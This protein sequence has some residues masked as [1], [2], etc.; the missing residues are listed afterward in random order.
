MKNALI[1]I[2]VLGSG[3]VL[4]FAV[5]AAIFVANPTGSTV[6]TIQNRGFVD[7][8]VAPPPGPLHVA[9]DPA[10]PVQTVPGK[11][12]LPQSFPVVTEAPQ[13]SP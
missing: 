4:T 3:V 5:A 11:P 1:V 8:L 7:Q 12:F 6:V 13:P 10:L 9:I 2:G